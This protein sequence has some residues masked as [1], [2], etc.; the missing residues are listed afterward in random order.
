MNFIRFRN[1]NRISSF[2]KN[3]K[4]NLSMLWKIICIFCDIVIRNVP[5]SAF[6]IILQ[7]SS[8]YISNIVLLKTQ[9]TQIFDPT[10][11]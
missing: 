3:I 2:E 1:S 6:K 10:H 11:S 5:S 4:N 9:P 8:F 7:N